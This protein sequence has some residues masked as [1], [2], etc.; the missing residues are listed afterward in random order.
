MFESK[1]F[2]GSAGILFGVG[3][4]VCAYKLTESEDDIQWVLVNRILFKNKAKDLGVDL[5]NYTLPMDEKM[6]KEIL[7]K[8][9]PKVAEELLKLLP[10][11]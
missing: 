2:W 7:R 6:I 9:D 8:E 4:T 11:K 10:K 1:W 5:M 3:L